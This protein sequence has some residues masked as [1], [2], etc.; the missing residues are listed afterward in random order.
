MELAIWHWINNM[1]TSALSFE[2]LYRCVPR[3]PPIWGTWGGI[4]SEAVQSHDTKDLSICTHN[5]DALATLPL[6]NQSAT[7]VLDLQVLVQ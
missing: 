3:L 5:A 2:E 1:N 7:M 6:R 4:R